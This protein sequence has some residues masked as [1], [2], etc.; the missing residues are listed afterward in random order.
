MKH[1]IYSCWY[2]T[3][4]IKMTGERHRTRTH[5]TNFRLGA[6][7]VR[8][9][10]GNTNGDAWIFAATCLH[11][12]KNVL[13]SLPFTQRSRS[14]MRRYEYPPLS[15]L[16]SCE[17]R[18]ESPEKSRLVAYRQ[19]RCCP[20]PRIRIG[21]LRLHH[22]SRYE[23]GLYLCAR[24]TSRDTIVLPKQFLSIISYRFVLKNGFL[25]N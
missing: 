3:P 18:A 21:A 16:H 11:E 14:P 6:R 25:T 13:V 23:C 7:S 10:T 12:A 24:W 8:T 4:N 20:T 2:K 15:H 9:N 5:S 1:R 19:W 22:Q 17:E